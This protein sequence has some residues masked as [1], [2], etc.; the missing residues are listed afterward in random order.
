VVQGDIREVD[1]GGKYDVAMILFGELNVFS[2]E[3]CRSILG[4]TFE[5]L[6]P[7]GTLVV[8]PHTY[9]AVQSIGRAPNTWYRSESGLFADGPHLCSTESYWI[10][11]Q[12]AALQCFHVI[13][14]GTGEVERHCSTTKAWTDDEYRELLAEAGFS[15][16]RIREDWPTH[17]DALML[18][19]GRRG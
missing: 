6:A 11:E 13:H 16:V 2:P 8:E 10:E 1:F 7:H 9:E 15:D 12:T 4:K 14:T 17:S 19:T 3:E 18:W 5:T